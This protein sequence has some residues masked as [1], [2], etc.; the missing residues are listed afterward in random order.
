MR[1]IKS[2]PNAVKSFFVKPKPQPKSHM[3]LWSALFAASVAA[4]AIWPF[5][6][7]KAL[8]KKNP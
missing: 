8:Q 4:F 6:A 7:G 5:A 1:K 2:K 3:K